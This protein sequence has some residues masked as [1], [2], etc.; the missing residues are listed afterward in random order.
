VIQIPRNPAR[1][2]LSYVDANLGQVIT[3]GPDVYEFKTRIREL[4]PGELECYYDTIQEEWIVTQKNHVT[5]EETFLLADEDLG[6]AYER[7]QRARNDAPHAETA[8]QMSDRLEKEQEQAKD[9]EMH[10]FREIAGDAA[11]RLMVALKRDGIYDHENI[12]GPAPRKAAARRDVR[13][14]EPHRDH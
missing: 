12:Y 13:V 9:A 10:G 5:E 1:G 3:E 4:A 7:V 11:E 2:G 8:D 6:R 14:R